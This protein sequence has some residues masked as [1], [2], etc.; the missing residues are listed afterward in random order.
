MTEPGAAAQAAAKSST[1]AVFLSYASE[2]APAAHRIC[3]ALR[4]A[5]IEV[6]FDQS[7]LR[8]G[9]AWD[10][11]IRRQI[12]TCALFIPIISS[13]SHSR[14]EGY[15]RLEWKLAV[16]RSHLIASDH[17]FLLPVVIDATP[18]DDDRIPDR[19]RDVQ[20]TRLPAGET[21]AA[22][23]EWVARLLAVA[24]PARASA[25]GRRHGGA[26]PEPPSTVAA[27]STGT[28]PP[29]PARGAWWARPPLLAA[30]ILAAVL[31]A[32]L[33]W[34]VGKQ[35]ARPAAVVPYSAED[36]RMTLAVLPFTAPADD[37]QGQQV[38]KSMTEAVT[39][40]LEA[41]H[42]WV[43]VA[44]TRSVEE[45]VARHSAPKDLAKALDVHFLVRGT[46]TAEAGHSVNLLLVDG[47][48]ERVLT[49]SAVKLPGGALL[50]KYRDDLG[51]PVRHLL[52][53]ALEEEVK[54]ES[55]KPDDQ[56][57]VRGLS[58][59]ALSSWRAH[60]GKE[61]KQGY[62]SATALLTRALALAPDDPLATWLTAEINLCDCVM[63]WSHNVEEQKSIGTA[64]LE[65]YLGTVDAKDDEMLVDKAELFQLRGRYEESL[66]ILD[67]VL[68]RDPNYAD[69]LGTKAQSL[70]KL[71]RTKE[72]L[73][74]VQGLLE[75]YPNQWWSLQEM[76]ADLSY[77]LGDYATAVQMAHQALPR[78]SAEDLRSPVDG[79]VQ[80]TLA[81]AEAQLGHADAAKTALAD[82]N[83]A[84]PGA[85]TIGQ[86]KKWMHPTADLSGFEPLFQGLRLAG[87]RD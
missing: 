50:P 49:N 31:I 35:L 40:D 20:W 27:G 43:Q 25:A 85:T 1:R 78:M 38:A 73:A 67:D 64:A 19:F 83:A 56:L 48:T 87:V 63:A 57:D 46:V 74:M 61:A 86:I 26:P 7:E 28:P 16:D 76:H 41:R 81:A 71:G 30:A 70:L 39:A 69:A 23:T 60:R 11:L 12:K 53:A 4:A 62:S 65:K 77:M 6:W 59:R 14:A 3:T 13:N 47:A 82:F 68:A 36:R 58:F 33:G 18:E 51:S 21:P 66:V 80:L 45:A 9:D 29:E 37:T 84:V 8:G 24:E 22:F 52:M 54:R 42:L 10:A 15:F 2:D 17:A 44:P 72:A 34:L 75:R 32:G 55:D 5:G 79:P